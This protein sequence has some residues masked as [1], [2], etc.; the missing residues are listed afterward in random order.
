MGF[1]GEEIISTAIDKFCEGVIQRMNEA[2]EKRNREFAYKLKELEFYKGN[3]DKQIKKIFDGWFSFLQNVLI[4]GNKNVED[5]VKKHYQREVDKF[6]KPENAI[7][8]K[9]ETMKYC[10]TQTGRVLALFNQISYDLSKDV[11]VPKFAS[12]YV[13]CLLLSTMKQEIL[14]QEIEPM[15]II[16]VLLND[17]EE[18]ADVIY[19]GYTYVEERRK[20]L[21]MEI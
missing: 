4:A 14:G 17:Y 18:N 1:P 8:L 9:I 5:S 2:E 16:K 11:E 13:T 10:G 7:S 19:D 21:F 12:V 6:M 20:E 15:T 3:Y